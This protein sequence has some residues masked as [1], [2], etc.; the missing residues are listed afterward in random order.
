MAV[1]DLKNADKVVQEIVDLGGKAAAN[2]SSVED[3]DS[4]LKTAID[5]FGRLDIL[6]N[7]AGILR[8]QSFGNISDKQWNDIISIHLRGI[9]KC[10]KA[11]YPYMVKQNYGRIVNTTSTSGIYGSFGQANYAAAVRLFYI[12]TDSLQTNVIQ[13]LG[14]LGFSRALALEGRKYNILV[15][16]IAPNAGTQLTATVLPEELVQVFKPIYIAPLVIALCSG[17]V[18]KPGTGMLYEVGSG[19]EEPILH[20]LCS[21]GI[22]CKH[23]VERYGMI[24]NIKARFVG[25]VIPGQTLRTEM[26]NEGSIIIFQT[27]V[28]DTNKLCIGS[29][30]VELHRAAEPRL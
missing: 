14:I 22:S 13:K 12:L 10:T 19:F 23:I 16:T 5:H 20:G 18:P 3:G 11:A 6:V 25:T 24:K 4:V 30:A 7:N 29:S 9:Y 15:N 1:N 21:F 17:S 2:S 26:W 8:D 27:R 28:K